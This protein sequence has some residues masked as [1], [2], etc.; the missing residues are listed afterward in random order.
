[1]SAEIYTEN[2]IESQV[3]DDVVELTP[4]TESEA[5]YLAFRHVMFDGL[6]KLNKQDRLR[7]YSRLKL[8]FR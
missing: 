3:E 7:L 2:L 6:S 4:H 5:Q 8:E 1:M